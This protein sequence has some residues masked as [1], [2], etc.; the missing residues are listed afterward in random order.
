MFSTLE[1]ARLPVR[2]VAN[3]L[4]AGNEAPVI[5]SDQRMIAVRIFKRAQTVGDISAEEAATALAKAGITEQ[6]AE[7]IYHLTSLASYQERFAIPPMGRE[8]AI[9]TVMDPLQRKAEAGFGKR[10]APQRGW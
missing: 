10:Q 2:Y 4:A 3:L 5:K 6:Q 7:A 1:N 9:E 8:G